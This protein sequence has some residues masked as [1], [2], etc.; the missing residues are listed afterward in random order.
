[1]NYFKHKTAEVSEKAQIGA[2][3]KIWNDA[4][5]REDCIIGENCVI[6]KGVYI[7]FD[8][9]IGNRVKIQ[10][11]VNLYHGII[12][13]DDVFIGPSAAFTNDFYPRAFNSNFA[14]KKTLVKKGAS[15][16]ANATIICG[17]TIGQYAMVGAGSVVTKDVPD[18]ALITGN[19]AKI[20]GYVCKCGNKL[21][22]NYICSI[23]GLNLKEKIYE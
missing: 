18:Y 11:G 20:A 13:E 1:M 2:E 4:Q 15:I 8:V 23:C 16:G 14:V 19:P 12:V 5:I 7:D 10:N 3:T 9:M 17:V 21:D 22:E 6:S